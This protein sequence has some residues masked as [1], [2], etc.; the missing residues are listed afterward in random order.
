MC[1]Q[2]CTFFVQILSSWELP[3]QFIPHIFHKFHFVF[4]FWC[5][6]TIFLVWS[7]Y[8]SSLLLVNTPKVLF[9]PY[10][11][12]DRGMVTLHSSRK[13]VSS[14]WIIFRLAHLSNFWASGDEVLMVECLM[15]K[16][17]NK[18]FSR[19]SKLKRCTISKINIQQLWFEYLSLRWYIFQTFEHLEMRSWW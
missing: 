17:R 2:E 4:H 8:R 7:V 6:H 10:T 5:K 19:Y 11:V 18:Q 16:E 14:N 9:Q 15:A 13:R 12:Q 1:F 3:T